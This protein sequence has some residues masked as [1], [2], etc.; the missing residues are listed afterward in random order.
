M[1]LNLGVLGHPTAQTLALSAVAAGETFHL[2][3]ACMPSY[4]TARNWILNGDP[5]KTA[6]GVADYRSG[7]RPAALIG[8]GLSIALSVL[9]ESPLPTIF[10]GGAVI[11]MLA[12]Y[13]NAL[14]AEL[15]LRW[16][17]WPGFLLTGRYEQMPELAALKAP[18]AALTSPEGTGL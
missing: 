17:Q 18:Q 14:P 1:A 5:A 12:M 6:K 7:Y 10:A 16:E 13:E 4:Y 9:A 2:G 11:A 8:M 3:S 15:R